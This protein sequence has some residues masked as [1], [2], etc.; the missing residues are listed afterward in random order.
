MIRF[1]RDYVANEREALHP[2]ACPLR[3]VSL[4]GLPRALVVTA[5]FDPLRDEGG[6]T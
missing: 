4:A 1:R 3:A 5:G 2:H 6:P